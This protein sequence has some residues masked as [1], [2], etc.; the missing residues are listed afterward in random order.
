VWGALF[1]FFLDIFFIYISNVIPFPGFPSEN[2][3]PLSPPP[4]PTVLLVFRG[5]YLIKVSLKYYHL[6]SFCQSFVFDQGLT[7]VDSWKSD[8]TVLLFLFKC[9]GH[10]LLSGNPFPLEEE[11]YPDCDTVKCKG[12]AMF[13]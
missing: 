1:F 6:S 7:S 4:A 10:F 8:G 9:D 3:H 12:N 2:P 11:T 5:S 13:V